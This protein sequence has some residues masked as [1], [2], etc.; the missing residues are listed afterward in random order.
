MLITP[1]AF[2]THAT[3]PP[4]GAAVRC[5]GNAELSTCSMVKGAAVMEDAF[6]KA[7][8]TT[9]KPNA[10]RTMSPI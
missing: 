5:V 1:R 9:N 8:N 3:R 10:P 6:A 2:E 4:T 7:Q